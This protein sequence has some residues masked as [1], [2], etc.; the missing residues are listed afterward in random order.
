MNIYDGSIW[1]LWMK[2]VHYLDSCEHD[3]AKEIWPGEYAVFPRM[4]G[5]GESVISSRLADSWEF[6]LRS[7]V[8]DGLLREGTRREND[9]RAMGTRH[10]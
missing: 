8:H 7:R 9:F 6:S 2:F 10:P 5:M 1:V 4:E 3:L